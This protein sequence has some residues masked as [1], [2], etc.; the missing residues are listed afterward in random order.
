MRR[1]HVME[2]AEGLPIGP[3]TGALLAILG[4]VLVLSA[5]N[6]TVRV[7]PPEEP[8]VINMNVKIEHEVRVKVD[9]ELDRA[10]EE[11]EDIF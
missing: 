2:A 5:C 3:R 11:D 6:P 1:T 4:T 7:E 8:I 10:F 9:E